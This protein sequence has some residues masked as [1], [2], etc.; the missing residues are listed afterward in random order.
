MILADIKVKIDAIA[1][2]AISS[3][4]VLKLIGILLLA[5]DFVRSRITLALISGFN[6]CA[7]VFGSDFFVVVFYSGSFVFV[8]VLPNACGRLRLLKSRFIKTTHCSQRADIL[9]SIFI[10]WSASQLFLQFISGCRRLGGASAAL[11]TLLAD[12][13]LIAQRWF[14]LPTRS[15]ESLFWFGSSIWSVWR[16]REAWVG[17]LLIKSGD[18]R[19][20]RCALFWHGYLLW[21]RWTSETRRVAISF[22]LEHF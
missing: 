16:G 17:V 22:S 15:R 20:S 19:R 8:N 14:L 5:I 21:S 3:F 10:F 4:L 11:L 2:I 12:C 18:K 7:F 1:N 6:N 9:V 13:I